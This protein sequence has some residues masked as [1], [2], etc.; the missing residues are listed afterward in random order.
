MSALPRS[1]LKPSPLNKKNKN[2]KKT[3]KTKSLRRRQGS[4][5]K[6][7][8]LRSLLMIWILQL[9]STI[10]KLIR[11]RSKQILW[12]PWSITSTRRRK[13]RE[14]NMTYFSLNTSNKRMSPIDLE[15]KMKIWKSK[16]SINRA[17]L[18][19]L[20]QKPTNGRKIKRKNWKI[21]KNLKDN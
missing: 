1:R 19:A 18:M 2:S 4:F 17:N 16:S 3:F 7:I 13:R 5:L 11:K 15:S 10:F 21:M 9:E 12:K 6:L 20:F 14:I 8:D